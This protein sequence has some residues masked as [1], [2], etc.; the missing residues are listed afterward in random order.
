MTTTH[1]NPGPHG[2][3]SSKEAYLKRLARIE[4]QV[5][6][7]RRMVEDDTYCI[8]LLTQ[9]SAVNKAMHSLS[10][11]LVTD[12]MNHCVIDAVAS[13]D[14]AVIEEKVQEVS[15]TIGRLLR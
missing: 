10:L 1:E 12:H 6:G 2:Y 15:A 13:G 9:I 8:D 11:G 4:G 7:I 3:S 14:E 5:R